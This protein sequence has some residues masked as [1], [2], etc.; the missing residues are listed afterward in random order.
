[1]KRK[2][3]QL[4]AAV[5]VLAA[6]AG[7]A[8]AVVIDFN[9]LQH[10]E[11]VNTQFV[12]QGLTISAVNPNRAHDLAII[13]DANE[14]NTADPDL[15]GP[16]WA[17]GNLAPGTDLMKMLIIA[18]NNNGAGDGVVD[19]P[20]DEGMRPAGDLIF[21]FATRQTHFGFD[22][23]DIEGVIESSS[24]EFFANGNS[25]GT[26]LFSQFTS[27]GTFFD[28]SVVFGDNFANRIQPI[29]I[30]DVNAQAGAFDKVVIHMGGSGAVDN[31]NYVP[32]PGSMALLGLGGI[33]A[34]RRRR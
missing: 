16:P 14:T 29:N 21:E 11:I 33:A 23:V 6:A 7:S 30:A 31:I 15:E 24:V 25:V 3:L 12:G 4:F 34:L 2:N 22:V 5:V 27:A 28:A 32:T 9:T 26:V 18:E 19:T 20:D 17:G 10:G 13:F 1:M 8:H